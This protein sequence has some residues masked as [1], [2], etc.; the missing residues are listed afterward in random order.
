MVNKHT[1][2]SINS[3]TCGV[4]ST[5]SRSASYPVVSRVRVVNKSVV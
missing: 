1:V 5:S 2:K 3:K 4:N